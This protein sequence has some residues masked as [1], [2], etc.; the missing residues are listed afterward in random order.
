MNILK[1]FIK[2]I[3]LKELFKRM[4]LKNINLLQKEHFKRL[5]L[6]DFIKRIFLKELFKEYYLIY[7]TC[8]KNIFTRP[9]T[10]A[11]R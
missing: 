10:Q 5:Y 1:D 8:N 4:F 6:K 9:V 11:D 7:F 2:R 3:Y